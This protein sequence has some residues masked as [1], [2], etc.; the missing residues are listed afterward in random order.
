M[1]L[2]LIGFAAFQPSTHQILNR[3]ILISDQ[4]FRLA[5][6]SLGGLWELACNVRA[7]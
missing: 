2:S 5:T 6:K 4:R 3:F 1:C 7:H